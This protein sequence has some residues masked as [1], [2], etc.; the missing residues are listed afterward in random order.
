LVFQTESGQKLRRLCTAAVAVF[1][2]AAV[3]VTHPREAFATNLPAGFSEVVVT[4]ALEAP[5]GFAFAPDGR[6]FVCEQLAGRVRVITSAGTLLPG[7]FVTISVNSFFERGLLG[8][9]LDPDFATNNFVYVYYTTGTGSLNAPPTPKNRVSRFTANGNVAVPGSELILL[10]LIASDAGNHNAGCIKFGPDGKLYISTG[11][12]GQTSANSQNR[13]NLSGKILRINKDGSI[14]S[15]NPYFGNTQGFRQEIWC[16]GL[17]NPWRFNFQPHTD[18]LFVGDVGQ[19]TWEEVNIGTPGGNFG[20]PTA[21]GNSTNPAF[22]NP[23]HVY[24]H[25]GTGASI[26]GGDFYEGSTFPAEYH[27]SYFYGDYVDGFI[28]RLTLD[29]NNVVIAD[30]P[31]ATAVAGSVDIQYHNND[32]YYT[33]VNDGALV[34]IVYSG[35]GNRA[36][37]AVAS[38]S[39]TA[40]SSPLTVTFSS[41]GS[42]DPDNDALTYDWDFG[43]G[44]AHSSL[45]NPTH[46]YT[47]TSNVQATLT[48][49]D[50]SNASDTAPPILIT[51][52]NQAPVPVITS[53]APN[54]PYNA[55][56]TINYAGTIT[57]SEQ[58]PFPSSGVSWRVVF[59]HAEHTHPFL[60]PVTGT[61]S[62]SF[63]VP[64]TGE[65]AA[66][67]FYEIILTAT[68]ARGARVS[69]STN[70]FP[71]T[72]Q[73]T[74][75]T[76]PAGLNVT[77]D[78]QPVL[79]PVTITGV[80][81]FQRQI[82]VPLPQ[83]SGGTTYTTFSGWSDGG[84]QNHTIVT[85]STS[86]TYTAVLVASNA[87]SKIP[88]AGDW[89]SDG[90]HTVGLYFKQTAVFALRNQ[91]APGPADVTSIYGPSNPG[92][93]G[94]MGDWDGNGSYTHA[95]YDPASSSFFIKNS[96]VPGPADVIVPFGAPGSGW[97][98]I[99]GDWDGNGTS[100]VGLYDPSVGAFFLRN[101][102][103]PGPANTIVIFGPGGSSYVPVIGDWNNDG[104]D[105]I[106]IFNTATSVF[107]LRD[108]N[109][110]GVADHAFQF[111]GAG[112]GFVPIAGNWDNT[113]GWSVGLYDRLNGVF[114]LTNALAPGPASFSFGFGPPGN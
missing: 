83:T 85:P 24:N 29:S 39:P 55:G 112:T 45:P 6:I 69:T 94:V 96:N 102:N 35:G 1:A 79:T 114:F 33:A 15:D 91:Q 84:A 97:I 93:T 26:T 30:E 56:D 40:G 110:P 65:Q 106:G 72:A 19:N 75:R 81:G 42:N 48:V 92:W 67:V 59:H 76:L 47:G 73:L 32:L 87:P 70:I 80:V 71:R 44:T 10:D 89:N 34:R 18:A 3:F 52:G 57:D 77:I 9:A 64:T 16:Y 37:L 5:T 20:W 53:P 68:D 23:I 21:E 105:T 25:N 111:G 49:R 4:N 28:R 14:P 100:T 17:R 103:T 2:L 86:T 98:P 108:S 11:D 7:A 113:G 104:V 31:F 46:N 43:D 63:V 90:T 8:I 27:D 22:T 62:G 50:P 38:A 66:D 58:N 61:T 82:G 109:T 60:G 36:P 107:F 12:G 54:A 51:P 95:V 13:A 88:L 99:A 101:S 41:A 78:G 74:F